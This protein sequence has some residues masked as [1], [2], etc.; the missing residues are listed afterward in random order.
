VARCSLRIHVSS[1]RSSPSCRYIVPL[2]F[3]RADYMK[4]NVH[5][6]RGLRLLLMV[7]EVAEGKRYLPGVEQSHGAI[8]SKCLRAINCHGGRGLQISLNSLEC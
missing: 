5:T 4:P 1:H 7:D 8:D 2:H 6:C 3:C